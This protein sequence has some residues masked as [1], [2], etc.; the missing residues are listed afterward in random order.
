M[1]RNAS[2]LR[3]A[4]NSEAEFH[5]LAIGRIAASL[6][7]NGAVMDD[8]SPDKH[9]AATP[10]RATASTTHTSNGWSNGGCKPHGRR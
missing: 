3:S 10:A 1:P 6:H 4:R 2:A 7:R 5:R 8:G 9:E